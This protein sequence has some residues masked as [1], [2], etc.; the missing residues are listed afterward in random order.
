MSAQIG[1][2]ASRY[3]LIH[4][5]GARPTYNDL[6]LA[7]T[8][9]A[10]FEAVGAS[11]SA[12]KAALAA[13]PYLGAR[14]HGFPWQLHTILWAADVGSRLEGD[15]VECGV[16][17]GFY[18]RAV[19][20]FL[21]FQRLDKRFFLLDTY[22]GLDPRFFTDAERAGGWTGGGY[23]DCYEDVKKT[24]SS[25]PNVRIV[26]GSVPE[27]LSQVDSGKI[28]YLSID[29]NNTVPEIAALDFFWPKMVPGAIVVLDD[30]GWV[31]RPEQKKAFDAWAA[32]ND[33]FIL[34]MPTGQGIVVKS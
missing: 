15:F 28:A 8:H 20:E 30:Y 7:T 2:F 14:L 9:A 27:T 6:G 33:A 26:R 1:K 24:F 13:D 11:A 22:Q 23:V 4:M 5:P 25:Y 3:R 17:R 32:R 29:M 10:D 19:A 16:N 18:A 34:R 31:N 12:Y 21:G